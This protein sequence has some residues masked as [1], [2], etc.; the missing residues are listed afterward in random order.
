MTRWV[1]GTNP[2][3]FERKSAEKHQTVDPKR[4]RGARNLGHHLL[5]SLLLAGAVQ[6]AGL[7]LVAATLLDERGLE[8][9]RGRGL[10]LLGVYG[11]RIPHAC[12]TIS[13]VQDILHQTRGGQYMAGSVQEMYRLHNT[14]YCGAA[15]PSGRAGSGADASSTCRQGWGVRYR[16]TSLIRNSPPPRTLHR[17]LGIGLL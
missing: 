13:I 15:L 7:V 8:R 11:S 10:H 16:G 4:L 6:L 14:M 1:R 3:T 2:S 12:C 17:T 9:T 5:L